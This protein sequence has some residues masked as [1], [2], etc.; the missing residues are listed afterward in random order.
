MRSLHGIRPESGAPNLRQAGVCLGSCNS[1]ISQPKQ[2]RHRRHERRSKK[3]K[4]SNI[5]KKQNGG[6]AHSSNNYCGL[7]RPHPKTMRGVM[8][9]PTHTPIITE[10]AAPIDL[11]RPRSLCERGFLAYAGMCSPRRPSLSF[12][13][14]RPRQ[15]AT[16]PA[17]MIEK[18]FPHSRQRHYTTRSCATGDGDDR[19]QMHPFHVEKYP[20]HPPPERIESSLSRGETT[21]QKDEESKKRMTPQEGERG[22]KRERVKRKP[23]EHRGIPESWKEAQERNGRSERNGSVP[24]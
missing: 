11:R 8:Q 6:R 24:K 9:F 23:P 19:F 4:D 2:K 13:A 3:G 1:R 22:R 18:E 5:H 15:K 12:F 17:T 10:D 20:R 7:L 21:N 14:A 16:H